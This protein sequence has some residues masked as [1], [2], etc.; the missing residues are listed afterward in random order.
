[1][2]LYTIGGFLGGI[3]S[4]LLGQTNSNVL[5]LLWSSL[6]IITVLFYYKSNRKVFIYLIL[7]LTVLMLY[8]FDF[9]I[10]SILKFDSTDVKVRYFNISIMVLLKGILLASIIYFKHKKNHVKL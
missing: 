4:F 6:L 1:M 10:Y 7:L 3:L 8:L 2:F 5:I 9:I